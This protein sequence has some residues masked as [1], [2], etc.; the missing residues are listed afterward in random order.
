VVDYHAHKIAEA[1]M[2]KKVSE[3]QLRF[4]RKPMFNGGG[5]EFYLGLQDFPG[6][7]IPSPRVSS[8][9]QLVA[10]LEYWLMVAQDGEILEVKE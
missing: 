10:I 6:M 1:A 7:P 2:A 3:A 5:E 8:R 9:E 4:I